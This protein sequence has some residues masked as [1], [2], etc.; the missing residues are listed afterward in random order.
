MGL[1]NNNF[2]KVAAHSFHQNLKT[3]L[4]LLTELQGGCWN[5]PLLS[6][7]SLALGIAGRAVGVFFY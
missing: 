3:V 2:L 6:A 7:T 5:M 4:E 1:R